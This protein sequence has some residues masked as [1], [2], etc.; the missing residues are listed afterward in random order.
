MFNIWFAVQVSVAINAWYVPFW[1][2]IQK[3]LSNGGGPVVGYFSP[4]DT[5]V[6]NNYLKRSNVVALRPQ[7][8]R[9]AKFVWGKP[10]TLTNDKKE[11][12]PAVE[13]YALKAD[14]TNQA[15]ISGGVVIDA[16]A[17]FDQVGKPAV[18][19]QMNGK[20]AKIWEELTGRV[21][22]QKNAIAIVLIFSELVFD[23]V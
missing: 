15:A 22:S 21:F 9:N 11:V 17:T 20:G 23:L 6:I 7:E 10:T 2:L 14:R 3:M 19:M 4:R 16:S 8:L 13:L 18:T 5:A 1:D 12:V